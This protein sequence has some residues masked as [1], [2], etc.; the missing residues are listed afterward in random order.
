VRRL[1]G[2][3]TIAVD[4]RLILSSQK[5]LETL[6]EEQR[7]REDLFHR[8]DRMTVFLPPLV[9][10]PEDLAP[11]A[12]HFNQSLAN[13]HGRDPLELAPE[14]LE[15]LSRHD[16]PGKVRDL[17]N[18]IDRAILEGPGAAGM[19][20]QLAAEGRKRGGTGRRGRPENDKADC[21]RKALR[22][23]EQAGGDYRMAAESL[24]VSK[25]TLYG[26]LGGFS[27]KG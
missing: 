23:M 2:E 7:L 8:L 18:R 22:A 10:R 12:D 5:S 14:V 11:L 21:R 24:G 27:R 4:F 25:S 9:E 1:G 6:R 19:A 20:A 17:R 16:W 26:W 3:E 15:T 13:R